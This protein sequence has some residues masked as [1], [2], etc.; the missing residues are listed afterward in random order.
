MVNVKAGEQSP[1]R[2]YTKPS[3]TPTAHSY[4]THSGKIQTMMQPASDKKDY[5][6]ARIDF[7]SFPKLHQLAYK[8]IAKW[9]TQPNAHKHNFYQLWLTS[10][11]DSIMATST[12]HAFKEKMYLK[13]LTN[14]KE[15]ILQ[16][17]AIDSTLDIWLNHKGNK[18][19]YATPIKTQH[20]AVL[21]QEPATEDDSAGNV[22][23]YAEMMHDNINIYALGEPDSKVQASEFDTVDKKKLR[24]KMD[25]KKQN[26]PYKILMTRH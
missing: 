8:T 14:Y 4:T 20:A 6:E 17:P 26:L 3:I 5:Q 23:T 16:C 18:I 15:H 10:W 1:V 22:P 19:R 7:P 13:S 25:T 2:T 9:A 12:Y 24:K 21:L 11:R